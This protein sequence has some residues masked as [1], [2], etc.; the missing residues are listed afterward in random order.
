MYKEA[1]LSSTRFVKKNKLHFLPKISENFCRYIESTIQINPIP[2]FRT[3]FFY[4]MLLN[5]EKSPSFKMLTK[6]N[7]NLLVSTKCLLMVFQRSC[8]RHQFIKLSSNSEYS[9]IF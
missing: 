8:Q 4:F 1:I 5:F 6:F 7:E 9:K 2:F 3:S